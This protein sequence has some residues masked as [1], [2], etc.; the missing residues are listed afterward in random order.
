MIEDVEVDDDNFVLIVGDILMDDEDEINEIGA[1]D[2]DDDIVADDRDAINNA[3]TV[4]DDVLIDEEDVIV[5][6]ECE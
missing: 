4:D 1:N 6:D 5:N 3:G 2:D